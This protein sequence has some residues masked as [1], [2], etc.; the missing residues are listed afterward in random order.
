MT[1]CQLTSQ[2]QSR[3]ADRGIDLTVANI[4]LPL[5]TE[6]GR[7]GFQINTL[8][9]PELKL[10]MGGAQGSGRN[11]MFWAPWLGD[12]E[13]TQKLP[14]LGLLGTSVCLRTSLSR[15]KINRPLAHAFQ[16]LFSGGLPLPSR[17]FP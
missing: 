8:K 5:M 3:S 9:E 6:E 10:K 17:G 11:W 7:E 16:H 15:Q 14:C 1:F 4:P 12:L 2:E 13:L